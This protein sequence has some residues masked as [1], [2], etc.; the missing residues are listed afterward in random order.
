MS[1]SQQIQAFDADEVIAQLSQGRFLKDIAPI[2]GL[3]KH[4][5]RHRIKNHPEYSEAIAAQAEALVEKTTADSI[6]L[7]ESADTAHIAR[8]REARQAALDWAKARDPAH[9]QPKQQIEVQAPTF[10]IQLSPIGQA[11]IEAIEHDAVQ[12]PLLPDSTV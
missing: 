9:W 12:P 10:I 1:D 11:Q 6:D 3:R 7:P 8:V 4:Q 2:Y 5:L